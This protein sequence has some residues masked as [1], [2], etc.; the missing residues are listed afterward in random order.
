MMIAVNATHFGGSQELSGRMNPQV[1]DSTF[2]QQDESSGCRPWIPLLGLFVVFPPMPTS[3]L[4]HVIR[5]WFEGRFGEPTEP[6]RLAWPEIAAGRHCLIAAPTGSGKTLSAF[7]IALDSLFREATAGTLTDETRILYVSPLKAL[8]NDIDR[9]LQRPLAEMREAAIAA[10]ENPPEIRTALRTG[11]TP[12]AQRQQMIRR[13]PHILVTTPESLYLILTSERGREMLRGVRTV[14]VDEIHALARDKRGSH[15]SLSLARLDALCERPPQR[16]GLSAT[17]RPIDEVARFLIGGNNVQADGTPDCA[18]IDVGHA[19]QL[20]MAIDVPECELS[21]VCSHEQWEEIYE[22]LAALIQ[23]HR[24]TLIFVNTR[25]LAERV[26]HRLTETLGEAAVASHHGSLS[27]ELRQSAERRLQS[28]ELRA[29]VA[30]ASLELGIDIGYIDLVCQISSPRAIATFLQRVGRSGHSLG[31]IPKGRLF[32]L[33]RDDLME[34]AALLGGIRRGELDAVEMPVAPID[35]LAQQ[36]VAAVAADDYDE[37]ELFALCRSAWPYRNLSRSV[38]SEVIEMLANGILAGNRRGAYLHHDRIN[39]KV[40]ARRGARLAAITSGGAIPDTADYRVVTE[41]DRTFV[42]TVNEDFAIESIA[43]DI[44]LLGNTSWRIRH[45]RGTEVVVNDAE[46]LPATVPFWF[47]EAPGRTFELSQNVSRLRE[48]LNQ[49]LSD[50]EH[51]DAAQRP[52]QTSSASQANSQNEDQPHRATRTPDSDLGRAYPATVSW[53]QEDCQLNEWAARQIAEYA[54]AQRN[55]LGLVPTG[56]RI[57]FE[58]FFDESGGMQLVIHSPWGIR[59]NRAWGLAMR[60]RFCRSFDFELQA[61]ADDDGIVLSLGTQH[62]FPVEQLFGMLTAENAMSLLEQALLAAPMFQLRW[63]WNASRALALLRQQ[64]GKRVPP[65]LQ[66]MRAEDLL[67]AVFPATTQCLENVVGD[68]EIPDHPLVRQTVDDCLR[69]AMD[70][71]RWLDLLRDVKAGEVE[72]LPRDTREPSPFAYEILNAN[73]YA[74]LD[75][76]PLEERRARAVATRRMFNSSDFD[77]LARLDPQAIA[78]VCEE[79]WPLVRSPDEL[80]DALNNF[81]ALPEKLAADWHVHFAELVA[82]ARAI[83]LVGVGENDLWAAAERL[84]EIQAIYA[85][86]LAAEACLQP[87]L[88]LPKALQREVTS[89]DAIRAMVH[90]HMEFRGPLTAKSLAQDLALPASAVEAALEALEGEGAVLRGHFTAP[91][92]E[93]QDVE[94]CDRRLLARIHR[95]TLAGARRRVRP[96]SPAAYWQ[97]VCEFQHAA[98][99]SQLDGRGSLREVIGQ[100]QGFEAP[101]VAWEREVLPSRIRDYD[102]AWL[103]EL[104]MTGEASWGRLTAPRRND[105]RQSNPT[106][107]RSAPIA[108]FER[109]QT[110]WLL[111]ADRESPPAD[112]GGSADLAYEAL[113]THGAL[114]FE[115]LLAATGLLLSQLE[116]ALSELAAIGAVTCDGFSG[117]RRLFSANQRRGRRGRLSSRRGVGSK[118]GRW[119]KFPVVAVEVTE[120][121]RAQQWAMLLLR[122]YGVMFRELLARETAAPRWGQL[123]RVLRRKEAQGLVHGGRFVAGVSG[124]QYA[125]PEAVQKLR[126]VA[127]R[128]EKSAESPITAADCTL[129][130]AVDPLNLSGLIDG[131]ER[132]PAVA[133]NRLALAHGEVVCALASGHVRFRKEIPTDERLELERT[134]KRHANTRMH[135]VA[136]AAAEL[137]PAVRRT[138]SWRAYRTLFD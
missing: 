70:V 14:I 36:I 108:L 7:M 45:V 112:L 110:N 132:V 58:R 8:S 75:D 64:G 102:P 82:T 114:F 133:T 43:G 83:K 52:I 129:V 63:R 72:L 93:Q 16:V 49:R 2:V 66:R 111:P 130:S 81:V 95:L 69:E 87:S 24:S 39:S 131:E 29:I 33:S 84:P 88:S 56:K 68:I 74:F 26:A 115:D 118:P 79:A 28:G 134:I 25:R 94:W 38:F 105:D 55:A 37:D 73:P 135:A 53:L 71:D 60:K 13:P 119:S 90:G 15:L 125:L 96:V 109:A 80:H 61:A 42:G 113:C 101:A 32:P 120:E 117:V 30:T 19:R 76:A 78:Q 10:G 116:T 41:T 23:S 92:S 136:Q 57:V 4:H 3:R 12:A 1:D 22:R 104:S 34:C 128:I 5:E 89:T 123:V 100:L 54:A 62:S 50:E 18:I 51:S 17:Q 137:D 48:H 35:I 99:A 44:F 127:E 9:N 31:L 91:T 27:R 107:T 47:G 40:R 86:R 67:T 122:R 21:A 6:Q 121:D 46:G 103:D 20:D 126:T 106:L 11:D 138:S 77:D 65:H 85:S 59:I 97:F 124:E 98:S